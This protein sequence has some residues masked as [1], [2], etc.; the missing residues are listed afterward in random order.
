MPLEDRV[1][2][3]ILRLFQIIKQ[4]PFV[5]IKILIPTDE[6]ITETVKKVEITIY[7]IYNN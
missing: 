3:G 5:K 7:L 6:Q 2:M 1:Q 4:H